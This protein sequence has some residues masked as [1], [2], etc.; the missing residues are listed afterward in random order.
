MVVTLDGNLRDVI[1]SG[2]GSFQGEA[3]QASLEGAFAHAR[4]VGDRPYSVHLIGATELR[5][6]DLRIT[7]DEAEHV[8]KAGKVDEARATVETNTKLPDDG[9]LNGQL[10]IFESDS[11]SRNT[12]HRIARIE[13]IDGGS[14]IV[15]ESPSLILGT[16]ILEDDPQ[17]ETEF[18]SLLAHEY[19][20]SDSVPGT[21]F[22]SGKRIKGEGFETTLTQTEFGQ[23]MKCH[24]ESTEGMA[25]GDEFIICD[26]QVGDRFRIP[27]MA[28]IAIAADGAVTG[29]ATSD[30]TVT[31]AGEELGQV[32]ATP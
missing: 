8:G 10:I 12:P 17:T 31:R 15:L 2:S 7:C 14:R 18:V 28:H 24:V 5:L 19:A 13:A 4:L 25:A 9:R 26:V 32:S 3:M 29:S 11:Y 21:Q 23:L 20:R 27:T 1:V 16:G 6:G 22:F 30:V